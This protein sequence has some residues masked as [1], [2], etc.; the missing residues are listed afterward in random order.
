MFPVAGFA[1]KYS[2]V[3]YDTAVVDQQV[4]H[5]AV[6]AQALSSLREGIREP[7]LGQATIGWSERCVEVPWVSGHLASSRTL[8]DI[9][10]SMSPPEWLRVL[11][12]ARDMG[13][14]LTGIDIIDPRRV[15]S[16]YPPDIRD[17][18]L[19]VPVRVEDFL[20]AQPNGESFDTITC[21]STLEHIGFD[22]ASSPEDIDSAFVRAK[23]PEQAS[24]E[25]SSTVDHEFMNA[26]AEFLQPGGRLLVTVPAGQGTPILHQD[27]L[28]LF[29]YQYE[30]DETSWRLLTE[31]PRF[32]ILEEVFFRYSSVDGWH[33]VSWFSDLADQTS[34]LMPFATGCALVCLERR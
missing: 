33:Q 23:S 12:A 14:S 2:S 21:L 13:T 7:L 6:H 34:A 32:A 26:A 25:R 18:V 20:T 17:D 8:L 30:Y 16:R 4:E 24:S 22:V 1:S 9:G 27:S 28:G 19:S 3:F 29:T 15:S 31:D 11:L 10:W 5:E